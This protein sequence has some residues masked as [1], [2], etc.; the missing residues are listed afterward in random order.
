MSHGVYADRDPAPSRRMSHAEGRMDAP[1]ASGIG[2]ARFLRR[3]V[4][5]LLLALLVLQGWIGDGRG[6]GAQATLNAGA[7][8]AVD[9]D[10]LLT[11]VAGN[12]AS[13][14]LFAAGNQ[15]LYRSDDGGET[16]RRAGPNPP[17]GRIVAS[18]DSPGVLL[19]G[20][21][22]GCLS[23]VGDQVPLSRSDDGGANWQE[24]AGEID[25][26]P[27]AIWTD[28]GLAL[29]ERCD[30]LRVSPDAG[31]TWRSAP[32]PVPGYDVSAFAVLG[33]TDAP[34]GLIAGTSE[35]G[36]S[37]LRRVEL[38]G[39]ASPVVSDQL[40]EYWGAG[41]LAGEGQLYVVA[42]ATGMHVSMDGGGTWRTGRDGLER[43]T[44][45]VDPSAETASTRS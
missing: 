11:L 25:V 40:L 17:R 39:A 3:A 13:S 32:P 19:A 23:A 35:G 37:E 7:V 16:W 36:T 45:S 20:S 38:D 14:A 5:T 10:P 9:G 41:A 43:V 28:A 15:G 42:S 44:I 6:A 33:G 34:A 30:G 1:I 24:V 4:V 31:Q 21:H 12:P 2:C 29:G 8:I 22:P 18:V 26:R 27:L